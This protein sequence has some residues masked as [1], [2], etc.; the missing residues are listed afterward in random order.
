[1]YPKAPALGNLRLAT[2][3]DVSR[4]AVVATSGFYYSPVFAWDLSPHV[5]RGHVQVLRE[6]VRRHHPRPRIRC[7]S[8]RGLL[9]KERKRQDWGYHHT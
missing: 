8:S 3:H 2:I 4:I 6:D 7:F 1:M 5:S 9:P